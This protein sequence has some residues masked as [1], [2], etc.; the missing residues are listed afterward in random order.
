M[1][2]WQ[3]VLDCRPNRATLKH[4]QM[5]RFLEACVMEF[6]HWRGVKACLFSGFLASMPLAG[7]TASA[8]SYDMAWEFYTGGLN[9]LGVEAVAE[10]APNR[11]RVE[12]QLATKGIS[13]FLAKFRAST[14]TVGE[15]GSVRVS[16]DL[17]V[18]ESSWRGGDRQ[19]R[20]EYG[21]DGSV[22]AKVV[23]PPD[24]DEREPVPEALKRN[25]IDPLSVLVQMNRPDS[26]DLNCRGTIPVFDGR[27]RYDLVFADLGKEMLSPSAYSSFAGE[28]VKCGVTYNKIAGYQRPD[29]DDDERAKEKSYSATIWMARMVEE[30]PWLPV[31]FEGESRRGRFFGHLSRFTA[32][33]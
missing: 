10:L 21:G 3:T 33:P 30:G 6:F 9:V 27:R 32:K 19:V 18:A 23:P 13:D 24:E 26:R 1:S 17:F 11:Y 20:A 7:Q 14:R 28:A 12:A 8:T 31:R 25:A 4:W 29:A 2:E 22:S 16:P 15:R 5:D